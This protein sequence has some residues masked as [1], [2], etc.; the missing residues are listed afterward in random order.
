RPPARSPPPHSTP[1]R[2]GS[3]RVSE[4]D[5]LMEIPSEIPVLGFLFAALLLACSLVLGPISLLF[6]GNIIGFSQYGMSYGWALG[7]FVSLI[8]IVFLNR[9]NRIFE[10]NHRIIISDSGVSVSGKLLGLIRLP[11]ER[12]SLSDFK[13]ID[14]T[15]AWGLTLLFGDR[16]IRCDLPATEGQCLI[17]EMIDAL[18]EVGAIP[19]TSSKE[20]E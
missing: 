7:I 5:V 20:E 3:V 13:D 2:S 19:Y 18:A 17:G 14:A 11:A 15:Q 1:S 12:F 10:G 9:S 4:K 16:R 6:S 8:L